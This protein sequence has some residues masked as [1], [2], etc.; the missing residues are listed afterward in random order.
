MAKK[1]GNSI[2]LFVVML[3]VGIGVLNTVL[4]SILDRMREYGVMK[5][6]GTTPAFIFSSIVLETAMLSAMSAVAGLLM[7]LLANWPM[8]V[9]G[10]TYPDPVSVGG[11]FIDTIYSEYVAEAFYMPVFVILFSAV[12]ASLIPAWKAAVADPVKSMRSY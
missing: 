1:E 8:K 4:M 12:A 6:M 2:M 7:S 11:I 9:Y 5:A 3:I 10:I